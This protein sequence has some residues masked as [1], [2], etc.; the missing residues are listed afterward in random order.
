[1]SEALDRAAETA[2]LAR[3]LNCDP[4]RLSYLERVPAAAI[5][6]FREQATDR[7]F[8]GEGDRLHRVAAASKLVPIQVTVPVVQ[9]A[10]GPLGAAALSGLVEP[11]RA[12]KIAS[13][14][15]LDFLAEVAIDMDPRRS[16]AVIAKMPPRT[17]ADVGTK[18]IAR[19]EHVTMGR[20]VA[21]LPRASL[22][23]SVRV[24]DDADLLRTAFVVEDKSRLDELADIAHDRLPGIVRA[25]HEHDLWGEA[26]D[27]VGHLSPRWYAELGDLTAG[28][29]PGVVDAVIRAAYR[30]EAFD[31]LL[32]MTAAMS[33]ESLR[34]FAAADAVT[35]PEILREIV[36]AAVDSGQWQALLPLAAELPE[37][38]RAVVADRARELGFEEEADALAP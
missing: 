10:I 13:K 19:E 29:G 7:L 30:T 16:A 33:Q 8:E 1:V 3:L 20:F 25:A 2:K 28:M 31:S 18:L 24:M 5:R 14:L 4:A 22:E 12:V 15:P 21:F 38:S 35:E 11:D 26:L 6:R 23:A 27:L 32:P 9:R 17:V 37:P 36:R 34:A